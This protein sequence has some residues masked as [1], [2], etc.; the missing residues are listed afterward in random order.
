MYAESKVD[1]GEALLPR[2]M[3]IYDVMSYYYQFHQKL[4]L[5]LTLK[6]LI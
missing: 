4:T 2:I 3:I 6:L 5:K 1:M